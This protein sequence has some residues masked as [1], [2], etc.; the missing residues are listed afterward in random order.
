ME[1]FSHYMWAWDRSACLGDERGVGA[2]ERGTK[3]E[4]RRTRKT[5]NT[6]GQAII[7]SISLRQHKRR[8]YRLCWYNICSWSSFQ[9][10]MY[11]FLTELG[12][13]ALLWLAW[14]RNTARDVTQE[15]KQCLVKKELS[16]QRDFYRSCHLHLYATCLQHSPNRNKQHYCFTLWWCVIPSLFWLLMLLLCF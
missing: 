8:A 11:A 2:S 7:L 13:L 10:R 3:G 6:E 5:G 1:Q 14:L 9:I 16:F 4:R 15:L 12:P